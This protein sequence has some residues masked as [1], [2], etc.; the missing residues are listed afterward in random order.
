M[1]ISKE[2]IDVTN[3]F[4]EAIDMLIAQK[5]I[6]GLQ[7]FTRQHNINRWNLLT[8]KSNPD[9]R[10]LKPEWIV[11]IVRDYHV[12]PKWILLGKGGMFDD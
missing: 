9:Q 4:F 12:S 10:G 5:K 2:G 6:R 3:R 8:V 7:T 1:N 11:Y